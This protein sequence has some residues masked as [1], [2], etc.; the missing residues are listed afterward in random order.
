ML[1]PIGVTHCPQ[2]CSSANAAHHPGSAWQPSS[3]VSGAWYLAPG[4]DLD[5]THDLEVLVSSPLIDVPRATQILVLQ[6]GERSESLLSLC[7]PLDQADGVLGKAHVAARPQSDS[8]S[9]DA[10]TVTVGS[11]KPAVDDSPRVLDHCR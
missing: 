7:V 8:S 1:T 3:S 5:D 10:C 11:V 9:W 4:G 6:A 2:A